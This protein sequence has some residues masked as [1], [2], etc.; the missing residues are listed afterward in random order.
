MTPVQRKITHR[1]YPNTAHEA[2]MDAVLALHC[3]TYNALLEERQRRYLAGEPS[4][5]FAAMCN[6]L[7]EWRGYADSLKGLNAQ[8]QQVTAKRAA[9]AFDAFFRRIKA[10]ETPGFPRFKPVQRFS[11]WGYKTYGDGWKLI[12]PNGH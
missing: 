11:G 6:A 12:Q 9:L 2:R 1:L 7:T 5:G 8:S 10:G 4:F 3:R